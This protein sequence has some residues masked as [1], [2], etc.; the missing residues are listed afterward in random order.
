MSL[1][2]IPTQIQQIAQS[3]ATTLIGTAQFNADP[4][5]ST[6]NALAMYAPSGTQDDKT[7]IVQQMVAANGFPATVAPA[8]I[9]AIPSDGLLGIPYW[10]WA[11]AGGALL[12]IV[13]KRRK[14]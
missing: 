9:A 2:L 1:T 10:G 6:V 3:I 7:A 13:M 8:V 12:L 14:R 5:N 4:V 11:V